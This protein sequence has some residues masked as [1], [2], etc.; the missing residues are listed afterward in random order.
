MSKFGHQGQRIYLCY[1]FY[2]KYKRF[3]DYSNFRNKSL[4]V[5]TYLDILT[6]FIEEKKTLNHFSMVGFWILWY[7]RQHHRT[8]LVWLIETLFF[9]FLRICLGMGNLYLWFFIIFSMR[10]TEKHD[11]IIIGRLFQNFYLQIMVENRP[12]FNQ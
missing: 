4:Q 12:F 3:L 6:F 10:R 8:N 11:L 7:P 1:R 5:G 2:Q 9:F